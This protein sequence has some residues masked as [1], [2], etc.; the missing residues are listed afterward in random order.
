M[1]TQ[2]VLERDESARAQLSSTL[3]NR[4][5]EVEAVH[6]LAKFLST[7]LDRRVIAILM[8][9]IDMGVNPESL[10]DG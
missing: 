2:A 5:T 8:E 3:E 4:K 9:F 10:A 6:S 7:G 1:D